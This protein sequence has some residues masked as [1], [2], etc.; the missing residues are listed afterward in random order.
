MERRGRLG[1]RDQETGSTA[2]IVCKWLG[3]V[4][5]ENRM[6]KKKKSTRGSRELGRVVSSRPAFLAEHWLC[7]KA[8]C[9]LRVNSCVDGFKRCGSG[10]DGEGSV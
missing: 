9:P 3:F 5:S 7:P 1:T 8:K 10:E 4:P 2:V 6:M